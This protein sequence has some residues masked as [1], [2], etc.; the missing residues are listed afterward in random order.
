MGWPALRTANGATFRT[1][2]RVLGF[3]VIC[4]PRKTTYPKVNTFATG[5]VISDVSSQYAQF[6]PINDAAVLDYD[7]DLKP[8]L[9]LVRGSERPSDAYPVLGHGH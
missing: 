8:D 5:G 1:S 2:T 9:F 6:G 3:E 4:A 7:G